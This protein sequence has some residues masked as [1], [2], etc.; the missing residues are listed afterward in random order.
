MHYTN[1][2][3]LYF[4][5]FLRHVACMKVMKNAHTILIEKPGRKRPLGRWEGILK[6]I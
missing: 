3:G 4:K 2:A 1:S 5:I 6:W